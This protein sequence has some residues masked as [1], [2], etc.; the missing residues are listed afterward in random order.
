MAED[1]LVM[2]RNGMENTTESTGWQEKGREEKN[3]N[4]KAKKEENEAP[5]KL[6]QQSVEGKKETKNKGKNETQPQVP[7][8]AQCAKGGAQVVAQWLQRALDMGVDAL[9]AEYR[10]LAKYTLPEMTVDACKANQEAGRNRWDVNPPCEQ[11]MLP[12]TRKHKSQ[13]SASL[14]T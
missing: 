3:K 13:L 10:S 5:S 11:D 2:G 14:N 8:V 6:Q 7:Q 4:K 12:S 9:R 1:S